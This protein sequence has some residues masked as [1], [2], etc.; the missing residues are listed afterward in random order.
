MKRLMLIFLLVTPFCRAA[1]DEAVP[2]H[3]LGN[4]LDD[5]PDQP[6]EPIR[7]RLVAPVN[8]SSSGLHHIPED[9]GPR[10]SF[11]YLQDNLINHINPKEILEKYPRLR[12]ID[13]SG[14]PLSQESVDEL[15]NRAQEA[16]RELEVIAKDMVPG[17]EVI[18][19][20]KKY[21]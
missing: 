7:V 5:Q 19:P 3:H 6:I 1:D 15:R 10:V 8:R 13:L 9:L 18:K 11:L 2:I 4:Q 21:W 17:G 14:N 16:G 20:A 12:Y